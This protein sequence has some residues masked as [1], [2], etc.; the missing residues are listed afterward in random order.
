MI[1]Y[2]TAPNGLI[3]SR[4]TLRRERSSA[5]HLPVGGGRVPGWIAAIA[6]GFEGMSSS[7]GQTQALENRAGHEHAPFARPAAK[8]PL[9]GKWRNPHLRVRFFRELAQIL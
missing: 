3:V 8:L 2:C 6:L 4:F 9:T 5:Y 1:Q 7:K